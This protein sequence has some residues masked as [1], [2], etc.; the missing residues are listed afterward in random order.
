MDLV[1]DFQELMVWR[2]V[3]GFLRTNAYIVR[4][5][6]TNYCVLVDPG[7]DYLLIDK[8]MND[9]GVYPLCV[10]ATHGHFDHI[11]GSKFFQIKYKCKVY[12]DA[13]DMRT[14]KMSNFLLMAMKKSERIEEPTI[15]DYMEFDGLTNY[16]LMFDRIKCP[17]HTPGSCI[18]N[19]QNCWFTGD[20][21][22][23]HGVGLSKL[24]G[25][26]H[27]LLRK[28]ILSIWD[29]IDDKIEIFPGHGTNVNGSILK[30]VNFPLMNFLGLTY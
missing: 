24:A 8:C 26:D 2:V 4:F 13:E 12:I 23:A 25:E 18:L 6:S 5:K 22:Y 21:V 27:L 7:L 3:N 16:G 14:V 30:S 1:Y 29:T 20:S 9:L 17:G 10:M 19:I 15:T 11:G 28:S